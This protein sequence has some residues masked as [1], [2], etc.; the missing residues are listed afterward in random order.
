[1]R[2]TASC[3]YFWFSR[4]QAWS[5]KLRNLGFS[6]FIYHQNLHE[7]IVI[8]IL[9]L[10]YSTATHTRRNSKQSQRFCTWPVRVISAIVSILRCILA[11]TTCI[12]IMGKFTH[13]ATFGAGLSWFSKL[14]HFL[15]ECV[16]KM[17]TLQCNNDHT[18]FTSFHTTWQ[19]TVKLWPDLCA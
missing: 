1:M 18:Q 15:N 10:Y 14:S 17:R 13:G 8:K 11:T 4:P 5:T 19:W 9:L 12:Y 6:N 3:A 2:V 7:P 16:T